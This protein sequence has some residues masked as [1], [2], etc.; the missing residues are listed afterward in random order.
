MTRTF[1]ALRT[2]ALI[3]PLAL[4]VTGAA[5]ARKAPAARAPA[6]APA[7]SSRI[8]ALPLNP[9][10]GADKRGCAMKTAS[11]LGYTMLKAGEGLKPG[12]A[13]IALISYIGYLAANG[14]VFDQNVTSPLPVGG[15]IPGF[16]EGMKMIPRGGVARLC[17]PAALGYGAKAA[18]PIPPNSDLVFQV[19]M[20]DFKSQAEI[21]AMRQQAEA[22][23][24]AAAAPAPAA[25]PSAAP[26]P[27]PK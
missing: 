26:T 6:A 18:G 23:E 24:K 2:A 13:D 17:I 1:R 15:V 14:Q 27:R 16:A 25:S 20:V 10:V 4:L 21:Q 3:A 5:P 7:A 9:V 19:E 22:A 8:I 12:D 11:G